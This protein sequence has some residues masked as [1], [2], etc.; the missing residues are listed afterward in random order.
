MI[1]SEYIG[2]KESAKRMAIIL[3]ALAMVTAVSCHNKKIPEGVVS[4]KAMIEILAEMHTAD[5]YFNVTNGYECDT[6][7]GEIAYTYNQIFER[8][9]VTKETFDKSL[10]Y[11]SKNPKKFREMYE[12]VV[13]KLNKK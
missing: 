13:L 9:G 8:Y 5:A 7:I 6:L 2:K 12:K 4:E 10:D 11:Y 1:K 3:L